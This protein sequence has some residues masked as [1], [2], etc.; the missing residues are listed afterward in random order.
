M[1][2]GGNAWEYPRGISKPCSR[3]EK[4]VREAIAL[5][6]T[7]TRGTKEM[8]LPPLGNAVNLDPGILAWHEIAGPHFSESR[9]LALANAY[10]KATDWHKRTPPLTPDTTVPPI[11]VSR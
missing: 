4:A 6:A 9:I 3:V 1:T 11:A 5:L 10:E 2:N 7:I 8:T